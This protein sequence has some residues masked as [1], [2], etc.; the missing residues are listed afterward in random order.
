MLAGLVTVAH[1]MRTNPSGEL[2]VSFVG[3]IVSDFHGRESE[4]R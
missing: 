2:I 3:A 1:L 4:P